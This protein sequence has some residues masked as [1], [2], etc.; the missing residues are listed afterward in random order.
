[1]KGADCAP[2]FFALFLQICWISFALLS[3]R[4]FLLSIERS[5][6]IVFRTL[7]HSQLQS[8]P[9]L[10][11]RERSTERRILHPSQA[12]AATNNTARTIFSIVLPF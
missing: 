5:R 6:D 3:L 1:M 2:F 11:L 7:F 10:S 12:N 9:Q 4:P 8:G